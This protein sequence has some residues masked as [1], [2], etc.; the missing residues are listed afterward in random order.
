MSRISIKPTIYD[1]ATDPS[2]AEVYQK[3]VNS[4]TAEASRFS[5]H[6]RADWKAIFSAS[7]CDGKAFV[8]QD[9]PPRPALLGAFMRESDL[10]F[11]YAPRGTGKTW[12]SLLMAGA[13]A[14][15]EA[16]GEWEAGEAGPMKTL[17]VDGEVNL[18]DSI[19]RARRVKL[20]ANVLWLHHESVADANARGLN[21]A[22][23]EQQDA[24]KQTLLAKGIRVVFLDNL[25]CLFRGV[26]EN[27]ADSWEMVLPWLLE[28]RRHKITVILVAHAGR[29][30]EMRGTSRREDAAHWIL[31]LEDAGD[32]ISEGLAFRTVFTKNRNARNA[33]VTCPPLR[34]LLEDVD[35]EMR[36]H[37]ER[38]SNVDA[39]VELVRAGM[40]KP[41]DI[42]KELGVY[43]GTVS[44]WAQKAEASGKIIIEGRTYKPR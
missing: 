27:E 5:P 37:C 33:S 15:G 9:V 21:L 40:T 24:L 8:S 22:D 16:L 44:K 12:L 31:K 10:G 4:L 28:L 23:P 42:A 2:T 17:Y 36:I 7:L 35:G 29:N 14:S 1:P 20:P 19:D 43:P 3:A 11:V 25:S 13:V 6:P 41:G 34:W 39:L 30:G 26:A 32:E 38:H 18:P